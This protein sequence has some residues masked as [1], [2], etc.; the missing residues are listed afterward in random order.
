MIDIPLALVALGTCAVCGSLMV[1][2]DALTDAIRRAETDPHEFEDGTPPESL[3]PNNT[4]SHVAQSLPAH[5]RTMNGTR[6]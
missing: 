3:D 2:W 4:Q 1:G 5:G 6:E